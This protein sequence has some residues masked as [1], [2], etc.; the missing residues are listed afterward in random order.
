MV[1]PDNSSRSIA[2]RLHHHRSVSGR[3][4]TRDPI[5]HAA[6][7]DDNPGSWAI[8]SPTSRCARSRNPPGTAWRPTFLSVAVGPVRAAGCPNNSARLVDPGIVNV[9]IEQQPSYKRNGGGV[10]VLSVIMTK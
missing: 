6:A 5:R 10:S 1:V 9:A 4:P 8:A 3:Y 7:F 2:A